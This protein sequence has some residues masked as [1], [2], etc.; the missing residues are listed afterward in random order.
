[1]LRRVC[2]FIFALGTI[3][4]FPSL[5]DAACCCGF[6]ALVVTAWLA[7]V[8]I[9]SGVGGPEG[10]VITQQL[11]DQRRVLVA[12]LVE[13]IELS[14]GLIERLQK[15]EIFFSRPV[16]VDKNLERSELYQMRIEII[17][18]GWKNRLF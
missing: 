9:S 4:F 18:V 13:G 16:V 2:V 7:V 8:T 5:L 17:Q 1:M 12:V 6:D 15:R 10:Q 3:C 11:H 14:N